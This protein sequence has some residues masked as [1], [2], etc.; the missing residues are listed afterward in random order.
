V[1]ATKRCPHCA[2]EILAA[3]IKCKH[4]GSA[5]SQSVHIYDP[6][7]APQLRSSPAVPPQKSIWKREAH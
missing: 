6:I 1:E 7:I 3:A 5:L 4:C 2:E